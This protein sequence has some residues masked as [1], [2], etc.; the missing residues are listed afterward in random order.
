MTAITPELPQCNEEMNRIGVLARA[1]K[2]L[3]FMPFSSRRSIR[4]A[5]LRA[6]PMLLPGDVVLP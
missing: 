1:G 3:T 2:S 5:T 4:A 6:P